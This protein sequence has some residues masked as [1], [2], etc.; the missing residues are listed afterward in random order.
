MANCVGSGRADPAGLLTPRLLEEFAGGVI[1]L[2]VGREAVRADGCAA[3]WPAFGP[4]MLARVGD[5]SG[6]PILELDRFRNAP[7][8]ILAAFWATGRP[9][10]KVFRETAVNAPGRLT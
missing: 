8:E 2:T 1:R 4:S 7:G 3:G 10:S 6:L 9:R 5:A